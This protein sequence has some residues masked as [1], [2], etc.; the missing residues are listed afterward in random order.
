[1]CFITKIQKDKFPAH[2][3]QKSVSDIIRESELLSQRNASPKL[4]P[5]NMKSSPSL[6]NMKSSA[7]L[8]HVNFSNA[9]NENDK[10]YIQSYALN[11][12][13]KIRYSDSID[14]S[15]NLMNELPNPQHHPEFWES[16]IRANSYR[17]PNTDSF[18]FEH[19]LENDQ[20]IVTDNKH[21]PIRKSYKILSKKP[22]NDT[23]IKENR[24]NRVIDQLLK[25][26]DL[27][28]NA[29]LNLARQD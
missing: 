21:T 23:K 5:V 1:M 22:F 9:R 24:K 2:N 3:R 26:H 13:L 18:N 8:K 27:K 29:N 15:Q 11:N 16:F 25:D 19:Y 4:P 20:H 14:N 6:N 7:S 10:S 17:K 28:E 12:N